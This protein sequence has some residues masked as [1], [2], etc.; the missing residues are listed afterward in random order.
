MRKSSAMFLL[1]SLLAVPA[2]AFPRPNGD[3]VTG[4]WM[5]PY[6]TVAVRNQMCGN[7]LCGQV[8]WA[9]SDAK[10]DARE[11][12]VT[13]LIG[14]DLLEDYHPERPGNWKGMVLVPDMGHRFSSEISVL[15]P[16]RIRI[17]G[18]VFHGFICKSQ[19]WTRI[20]EVPK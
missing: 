14:L 11:S 10:A 16:N 6:R 12:G 7:A 8:V 3:A 5:N 4:L 17:S 13:N 15:D 18:C 1:L 9:S 2:N 20:G 19:V